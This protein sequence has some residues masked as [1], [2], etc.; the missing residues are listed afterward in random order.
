MCQKLC[1]MSHNLPESPVIL[2]IMI[3]LQ[4]SMLRFRERK[5]FQGY[6]QIHLKPKPG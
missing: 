1:I 5:L 2:G 3:I 4:V 6:A